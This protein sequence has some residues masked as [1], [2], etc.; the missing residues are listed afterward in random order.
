[1]LAHPI[2][3]VQRGAGAV[4]AQQSPSNPR[5]AA[6]D[7]CPWLYHPS[8]TAG[9]PAQI[10]GLKLWLIYA[11][12]FS[13]LF[14]PEAELPKTLPHVSD[15]TFRE[16][17]SVRCRVTPCPAMLEVQ[18]PAPGVP[19]GPSTASGHWTTPTAQI[20]CQNPSKLVFSPLI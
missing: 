11:P 18:C 13:C 7:P 14:Y 4:R 10:R 15:G 1:M 5:D 17:S 20:F 16:L 9:R 19:V 8:R 3:G 2:S 6:A 12:S